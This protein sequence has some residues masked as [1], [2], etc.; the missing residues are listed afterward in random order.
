MQGKELRTM[1]PYTEFASV[2]DL[3]MDNVP[4]DEWTAYIKNIL[5]ENQI[6]SGLLLELG[7]GTGSMTRRLAELGYDMIGIDS[8]EEMLSI[9]REKSAKEYEILYLCQDMREF[10]LYGTVAAV[11]SVC[12]SINYILTEEDLLKV[13]R[14]VNNYLDPGG[15]FIF[16]LDTQ[17]AYE[18]VL[19]DNTIAE[20]REEGSFIWENTYYEE[21]MINEVNLTLF[22]PEGDSLYRKHEET[23]LRRAYSLDTIK[24]LIEQA[25]MELVAIYDALTENKPEDRSE[26]VYVIAREKYQKDKL[27]L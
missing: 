16:D 14:L 19:G 10:E 27:Y 2:Y 25:G 23:H 13:F 5:N 4:Y 20:N 17:F 9:A 26:R 12:D 1:Q 18:T 11:I 3:F 7:C 8:S 6:H 15:L 22:I 21:E 24:S